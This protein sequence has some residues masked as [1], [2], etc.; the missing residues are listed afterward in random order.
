MYVCMYEGYDVIIQRD[1]AAPHQDG[2]IITFTKD[3]SVVDRSSL[4]QQLRE[5]Y[6]TLSRWH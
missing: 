2:K 5:W 1:N 6:I 3:F 4:Q